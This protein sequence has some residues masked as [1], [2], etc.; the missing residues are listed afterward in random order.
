VNAERRKALQALINKLDALQ[1]ELNSL[2]DIEDDIYSDMTDGVKES[3]RGERQ[4]AVVTYLTEAVDH[5]ESA[6]NCMGSA[7]E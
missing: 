3:E 5:L 7:I 4:D 1:S 2:R 6:A